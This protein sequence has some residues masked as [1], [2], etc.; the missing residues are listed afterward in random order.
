[1][2][3]KGLVKICVGGAITFGVLLYAET[4]LQKAAQRESEEEFV[5][6]FP[7]GSV[8]DTSKT[9]FIPEVRSEPVHHQEVCTIA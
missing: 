9:I 1:M 6:I 3:T 7:D 5:F 4:L 8:V 2:K